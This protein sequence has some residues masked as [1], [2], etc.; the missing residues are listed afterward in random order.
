MNVG[1][2]MHSQEVKNFQNLAIKGS[3]SI[4]YN[5]YTN[6]FSEEIKVK[7]KTIKKIINSWSKTVLNVAFYLG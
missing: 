3:Q 6:Y 1:I 2:K 7:K 5:L 4:T